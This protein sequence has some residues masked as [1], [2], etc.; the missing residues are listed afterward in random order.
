MASTR[1]QARDEPNLEFTVAWFTGHGYV[2]PGTVGASLATDSREI[3][4]RLATDRKRYQPGQ[5]ATVTIRTSDRSGRPVRATVLLRG[6][7]EKLAAMG[8]AELADPLELLYREVPVGLTR[9]P[10]VSHRVWI[11]GTDGGGGATGGGGRG[12]AATI[13]ATPCRSRW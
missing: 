4:V 9:G 3:R 13:C 10:A 12:R 1:F 11:P 5:T 6:I 8:V 2:L 7:D